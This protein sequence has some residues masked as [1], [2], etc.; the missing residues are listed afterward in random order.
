MTVIAITEK[1]IGTLSEAYYKEFCD[2]TGWAYVSLEQIHERGINKDILKFKKGFDRVYVKIPKEIIPEIA[3]ISTP[4]NQNL[5]A[6]SYVY[7]FLA[8]YVG[9]GK[10]HH[11]IVDDR[12]KRHFCWVEVKTGRNELSPNQVKTLKK[13]SLRLFRFRVPYPL[14]KEPPYIHYDQVNSEYLV[15]HSLD[16][17]G[18]QLWKKYPT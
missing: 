18:N 8:C 10:K 17:E 12:E 11:V 1:L 3:E 6:P 7:D 9:K 4:T 5:Y 13:L 15:N 16:A 2:Q 14:P